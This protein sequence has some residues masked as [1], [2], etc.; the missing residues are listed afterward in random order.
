MKKIKNEKNQSKRYS[1][2][3]YW[4]KILGFS[5]FS[6]FFLAF[7]LLVFSEGWLEHY[8][9]NRNSLLIE[10]IQWEGGNNCYFLNEHP[11]KDYFIP[12]KSEYEWTAVRSNSPAG[13]TIECG[14]PPDPPPP[15]N[16]GDPIDYGGQNYDTVEIG[17]QCWMAENLN[18]GQMLPSAGHYPDA[19]DEV[20]EKWCYNNDPNNCSIYGGLYNW[21]EAMQGITNE[22]E[23][24]R[25]ICPPGWHIPTDEEWH[26]LELF[27]QN[28][29]GGS[30]DCFLN[31]GLGE[32]CR[33]GG[34]ILRAE[35]YSF[36]NDLGFSVLLAGNYTYQNFH[37]IE[38][39]AYFWTSSRVDDP[40]ASPIQR[41]F[42]GVSYEYHEDINR[43]PG[44]EPINQGISVRCIKDVDPAPTPI[45]GCGS[46]PID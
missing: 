43:G 23:G 2:L 30:G 13:L 10:S 5:L 9:V 45:T 34:N 19:C 1:K 15:F 3:I 33:P 42:Y 36:T 44:N 40:S 41:F 39:T 25:G 37:L 21:H 14:D 20:I 6:A 7:Y 17:D 31:W 8:R 12:A 32:R 38:D 4:S 28:T 29:G 18:I 22:V 24:V 26:V 11:S 46:V 35:G 27:A 16:C